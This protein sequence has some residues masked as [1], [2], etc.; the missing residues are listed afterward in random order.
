MRAG[1][2]QGIREITDSN[3]TWRDT[4]DRADPDSN[5]TWRDRADP[6]YYQTWRDMGTG[7]IRIPTGH[8]ETQ[9]TDR[10]R[11]PLDIERHR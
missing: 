6:D 7:Q 2:T 1:E 8:R 5:W 10:S 4:G 3:Q 9:V 11:F